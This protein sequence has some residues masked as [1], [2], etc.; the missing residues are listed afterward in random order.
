[1]L[2]KE[3]TANLPLLPGVYFFLSQ[4]GN[5]LYIGK[6]KSLRKR[7]CSY[8]Y[9]SRRHPHKI[10]Q[11]VRYAMQIDYEVCGS[12]LEAVLLESRRIKEYQPPYNSALKENRKDWFIRISMNEDFPRIELV[13][14]IEP[15]G[16][17]YVGPFS[18]RRWTAEVLQMIHQLFPIR[19]CEGQLQPNPDFRPCFSYHLSR[20]D[21]PC[22]ARVSREVYRAMI[23]DAIRLINGEPHQVIE[24]LTDKRNQAAEQLRFESAAAL[25]RRIEQIERVFVYLDVH[26]R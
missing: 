11:L 24:A 5:P 18:S 20:C 7:V 13:F 8:L 17:Q 22:A 9:N 23:D 26:R 12:E 3:M 4:S 16:A 15:D 14:K 6:A 19:T 10:K 21:A 1:M 25:Q 2:T